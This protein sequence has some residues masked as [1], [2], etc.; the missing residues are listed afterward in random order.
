MCVF[1]EHNLV[2]DP[3]F[4]ALDL[5][6]CRNVLIYMTAELQ[7]RVIPLFHYALVPS[8]FL[9]LGP[10]EGLLRHTELF[11]QVSQKWRIFRRRDDVRA[12]ISF[13]LA[14]PAGTRP[15]APPSATAPARPPLATQA[16]ERFL[17]DEHMPASAVVN[18]AG[19]VTLAS[20]LLIQLALR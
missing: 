12:E 9:C 10:S 6:S 14:R 7:E 3:P 15:V 4:S 11:T 2:R 13:P 19:L 20:N 16:L 8:G 17:L 5:V 1:S 18:G